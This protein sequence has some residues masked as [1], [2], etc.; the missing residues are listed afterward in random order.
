MVGFVNTLMNFRIPKSKEEISRAAISTSRRMMFC[1]VNQFNHYPAIYSTVLSHILLT[2]MSM[3]T[4]SK[5]RTAFGPSETR[6]RFR[7]PFEGMNVR[8]SKFSFFFLCV[9]DVLCR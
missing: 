1:R 5:A 6:T 4:R 3:G 2:P 8:I 9:C 7:I